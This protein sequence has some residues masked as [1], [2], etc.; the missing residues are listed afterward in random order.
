MIIAEIRHPGK[1]G[2]YF[3]RCAGDPRRTFW[4]PVF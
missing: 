4:L 3:Q 2:S 1:N